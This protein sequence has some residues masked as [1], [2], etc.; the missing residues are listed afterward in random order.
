MRTIQRFIAVL[1]CSIFL[2][3]PA[4]CKGGKGSKS[5]TGTTHV[6]GYTKKNGTRVAAHD[7]TKANRTSSDNW[8][9]KGNVNPETGKKGTK[10]PKN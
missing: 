1:A 6:K 7:R 2:T 10:K 8:S 3:L 4:E 9:T 5:S